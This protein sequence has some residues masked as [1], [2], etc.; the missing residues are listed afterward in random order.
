MKRPEIDTRV[1]EF[2]QN[3]KGTV[4]HPETD[5][6]V[7]KYRGIVEK[8]TVDTRVYKYRGTVTK[9]ASTNTRQ[10]NYYQYNMTLEYEA[11]Q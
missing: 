1:Y 11:W 8:P 9:P 2:V 5:T 3:Y 10:T 7:Y 4:T 6:R